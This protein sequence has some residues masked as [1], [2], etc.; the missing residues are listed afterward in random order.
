ME[1]QSY[2]WETAKELAYGVLK[3]EYEE[4]VKQFVLG[5]GVFV[6][7]L[8]GYWKESFLLLSPVVAVSTL[9]VL[10]KTELVTGHVFHADGCWG[11]CVS[12]SSKISASLQTLPSW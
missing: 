7:L 12:L 11:L 9:V 2:I 1:I 10:M 6:T 5:R 8:T 3:A 4:A